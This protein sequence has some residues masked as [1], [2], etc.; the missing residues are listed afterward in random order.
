MGGE[1]LPSCSD[2]EQVPSDPGA[3]WWGMMETV[4]PLPANDWD[5]VIT[6]KTVFEEN[7]GHSP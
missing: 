5:D 1:H 2:H 7:P 4:A 6:L 3:T